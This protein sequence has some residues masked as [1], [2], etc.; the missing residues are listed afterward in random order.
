MTVQPSDIRSWT[1]QGSQDA[2][3]RTYDSVKAALSESQA[4]NDYTYEVFLQGS[5]AN[6]TN[7]R[8]DSDVDIVVML[9]STY[10]PDT[11]R[12]TALEK[13]RF[14]AQRIPG[15]TGPTEFRLAVQRA[16]VGRFGAAAVQSKNKC[17]FVPKSNGR[18][19]ADVVPAM[20]IRRFQRFPNYGDP[21]YV[22]GIRISPLIGPEIVNYPKE[23]IKNGVAK[24]RACAERYKPAVRQ[25][26][27]LRRRAVDH[28]LI[29]RGDAPGYLLECLVYNVAPSLFVA[30]EVERLRAVVAYLVQ[31]SPEAMAARFKS[32]DEIHTLFRND[33]G[34]HSEYTA[35]RV[36][37]ALWETL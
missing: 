34:R 30:D 33:P 26:K 25:V 16:L 22:E 13:A 23:H 36:V 4:L 9:T 27:R 7:T 8:G 6:A 1:Q 10:V 14:D 31:L 5:Y 37:K 3:K 11:S 35:A 32:C 21:E 2:A 18:V 29:G 20:Q 17:L 12:L 28:G 24:N 19:D 15:R